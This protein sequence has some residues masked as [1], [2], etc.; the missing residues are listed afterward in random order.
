MNLEQF[1]ISIP[2]HIRNKAHLKASQKRYYQRNK[3]AILEKQRER[4]SKTEKVKVDR[5]RKATKKIRTSAEQ[6][7]KNW[8][9]E[10]FKAWQEKNGQT[11][12][13]V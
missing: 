3:E 4:R 12:N 1:D 11:Q 13:Q 7:R 9:M 8:L 6:T 10:K 5:P 2:W